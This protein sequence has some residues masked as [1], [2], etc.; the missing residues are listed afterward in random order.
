MGKVIDMN[1]YFISK[2]N[3]K[4]KKVKE[5]FPVPE[6][7]RM[8]HCIAAEDYF[9]NLK[10]EKDVFKCLNCNLS[11]DQEELMRG[12]CPIGH[13]VNSTSPGSDNNS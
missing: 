13:R 1:S 4:V 12:Y 8:S 11:I 9:L 3:A 10:G 2:I 6:D 7:R 5:L